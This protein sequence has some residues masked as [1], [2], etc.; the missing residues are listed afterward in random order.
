MHS[1]SKPR[2]IPKPTVLRDFFVGLDER[3]ENL[4]LLSLNMEGNPNLINKERQEKLEAGNLQPGVSSA[5]SSSGSY[6]PRSVCQSLVYLQQQN[7]VVA[8]API[9]DV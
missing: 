4:L 7:Y 2:K 6:K 3:P 5:D 1:K 9:F 8:H